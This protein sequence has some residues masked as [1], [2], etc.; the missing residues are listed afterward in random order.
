MPVFNSINY[1]ILVCLLWTLLLGTLSGFLAPQ[2][3]YAVATSQGPRS[4]SEAASS[5]TSSKNQLRENSKTSHDSSD[6]QFKVEATSLGNPTGSNSM[7]PAEAGQVQK[8]LSQLPKPPQRV[9]KG[10]VHLGY[11]T[12]NTVSAESA[13]QSLTVGGV[14]FLE[15]S[16]KSAD[17]R[18]E[19]ELNLQANRLINIGYSRKWLLEYEE[20]Q[21][22]YLR[23]G[24]I[25]HIDSFDLIAGFINLRHFKIRS[26][27]GFADFFNFQEKYYIEFGV[28]WGQTG[29]ATDFRL[30]HTIRY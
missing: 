27:V 29:V 15:P 30:G 1:W 14:L 7:A 11:L 24:L 28:S 22:P 23:V 10:G 20:V 19:I 21:R 8:L 6:L 25:N 5:Q 13:T 17:S 16:E 12:G 2:S 26:A 3:C 9:P 4:G 18:N